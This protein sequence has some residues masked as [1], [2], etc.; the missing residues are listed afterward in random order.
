MKRELLRYHVK[1]RFW[2]QEYTVD[3]G[4]KAS[5]V[6][7]QRFYYQTEAWSTEYDIPP[8]YRLPS[9]PAIPGYPDWP[10]GEPTP[11]TTCAGQCP[12]GPD[13]ACNHTIVL[14]WKVPGIR[15]IYAGGHCHA[16]SCV[17]LS[18]YINDTKTGEMSLLCDQTPIPGKGNISVDRFDEK[19]YIHIPPCLW[20][21]DPAEGLERSIWLPKDTELVSITKKRNTHVGHFGEMASWQMRGVTY[22]N[23]DGFLV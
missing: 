13:C 18:L 22:P 8:A 12:D 16:P 1:I 23:T 9:E 19:G 11:G 7:L 4:G 6:D 17:S 14:A 21:D 5:H 10:V 20:S 15:I 2:F 3:A